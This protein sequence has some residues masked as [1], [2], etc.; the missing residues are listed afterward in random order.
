MYRLVVRALVEYFAVFDEYS[1]LF[2]NNIN[3]FLNLIEDIRARSDHSFV[4][5]YYDKIQYVRI[6]FNEECD[7]TATPQCA[8]EKPAC[9]PKKKQ[10]LTDSKC[11]A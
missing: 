3:N 7:F 11:T 8:V 9:I 6:G 1:I 5:I 2:K 10:I 4:N